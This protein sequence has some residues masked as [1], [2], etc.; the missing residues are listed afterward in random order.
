MQPGGNVTENKLE[1][2]RRNALKSTGPKSA[3]GKAASSRNAIRHGALSAAPILPKVENLED[4]EKH[5][6]GIFRSFSPID[7]LEELLTHRLAT[8]S[9]RLLRVV[10]YESEV[11]A[12]A[13]ATA[14]LDLKDHAESCS[15]KTSDPAEV[16]S[17]VAKTSTIIDVLMEL[18]RMAE[19]EKL[20]KHVAVAILLALWEELPEGTP[21][22]ISV[23]GV[24]DDDAQLN[25]FDQWTAGLLRKAVDVYAAAAR[26]SSEGLIR[27][28]IASAREDDDKARE[29]IPE[30]VQA[31]KQWKLRLQRERRSRML[32]GPDVL[33]TVSRYETGLERSFFRTL[34]ELQRLQAARSGAVVPPPAAIDVDVSVHQEGAS[35][36]AETR[37]VS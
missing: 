28:T 2:N 23:P 16:R 22:R 11:A 17:T 36:S 1:A 32:L 29:E 26:M 4:W 20:N 35:P 8:L 27:K 37:A 6:D 13:A 21:G 33:G 19:V 31:L 25:T 12:A 18:P 15:R 30:L 24:P 34:H 7:Y 3:S 5:R 14:E 10:R 9:W